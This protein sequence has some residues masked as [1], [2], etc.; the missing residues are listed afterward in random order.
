MKN[1]EKTRQLDLCVSCE[2]C[3]AV[4]PNGAIK[5]ESKFGQFLPVIDN[6]KCLNCGMCLEFCPGIN[7]DPLNLKS[8]EVSNNIFEDHCLESYTAFSNNLNIRKKSTSGGLITTLVVELIKNKEFEKAFVLPTNLSDNELA[9]IKATNKIDEVL[10]SSKSKYIPVSVYNVIEAFKKNKDLKC[11]IVGTPCQFYGIKRFLIKNRISEKN[12]LFLGLFCD[13]TF[14]F[15]I[16][17]YFKENYAKPNEKIIRFDFR[18]KDKDGWPGNSKVYFNSGR[19]I[20]VNRKIRIQLKSFF[21]LNRCLF[22]VDKLNRKADISFGDCYIKNED[23]YYGKSSVIVRTEKGKIIFDKYLNLFTLKKEDL[24]RIE[25]SQK[26]L[27]KIKNLEYAKIFI[28]KHNICDNNNLNYKT[29]NKAEKKLKQLQRYIKWGKHYDVR[30]IKLFLSLSKLKNRLR[31]K[32]KKNFTL[33]YSMLIL[34][35]TVL[36]SVFLNREGEKDLNNE[37]PGNIIIVGS[38]LSNKGAQAMLFTTVNQIKNRFPNKNIYLFTKTKSD[39]EKKKIYKFNILLWDVKG[40]INFLRNNRIKQRNRKIES[41]ISNTDFFIDISGYALSSNFPLPHTIAYLSNIVVAKKYQIPYY[42]FP[43]SVGPFS[44]SLKQ[45]FILYP[46]L[47][48]CLSYPK[49]I[50]IREKDGLKSISKFTKKNVEESFD[51]VL[52]NKKYDLSNIYNKAIHFKKMKIKP[53]SVAVIP[54]L[55]VFERMD[56][57]KFD[58]VYNYLIKILIKSGKT[59]YLL[60]HSYEDLKLCEKIKKQ[61]INNDNV[62]LM[63]EDFNA[64]ELEDIIK[65]FDFIITSRYHSIVHAYK[66][67][68]PALVVGWAVKYFELL[69]KFGQLN[70]YFDIDNKLNIGDIEN[71]LCRIIKNYEKEKDKINIRMNVLRLKYK[72]ESI[73]DILK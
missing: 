4:C 36:K 70:Y 67:G 66:Y 9:R 11:V 2:I 15:N 17:K 73:F 58:F 63:S 61:F 23:S 29:N 24:R 50:F 65:Q 39:K 8:K 64:I 43:Q 59:V 3:S 68:V 27:N 49:K 16:I 33:P 45:K 20:I 28:K 55:R 12:V 26:V 14:N 52:Q 31:R 18:T 32:M 19:K 10:K 62:I 41:I 51:I 37:H 38:N 69:E 54:N 22:C 30:K 40:R 56:S 21:Q 48:L 44:Y 34:Y 60:R 46:L 71:G 35:I 7:I 25:E 72:D 47:K 6:E 53:N 13:K 42:I 57:I 1:V 5:M